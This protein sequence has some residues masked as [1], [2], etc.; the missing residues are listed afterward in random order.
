VALGF[1]AVLAISL[2]GGNLALQYGAARLP[3]HATALIMLS[4]IVFASVSSVL[5]GAAELTTRTWVGAALILAAAAA[6]AWAAR[7]ESAG[8][9]PGAESAA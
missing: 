4:E 7:A 3:A 5:L 2:L 9:R 6:S 8:N 1:G